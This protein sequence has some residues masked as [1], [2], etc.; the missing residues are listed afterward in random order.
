MRL[1]GC[2]VFRATHQPLTGAGGPEMQ[3]DTKELILKGMRIN[4]ERALKRERRTVEL[5]A[6]A[7]IQM[8]QETVLARHVAAFSINTG[9]NIVYTNGW[10]IFQLTPIG[11]AT[12]AQD[13]VV[14]EV[15][16]TC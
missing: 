5:A 10:G 1:V 7:P 9:D 3:I 15:V 16:L 2:F 11:S 13:R 14:E 4:A 8:R 12:I 6:C